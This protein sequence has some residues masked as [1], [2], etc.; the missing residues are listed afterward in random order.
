MKEWFPLIFNRNNL[1]NMRVMADGDRLVAHVG[2][3]QSGISIYGDRL[4]TGSIGAVCTHPDYRGKGLA[5]VLFADALKKQD[6]RQK[7]LIFK[8]NRWDFH[9]FAL[10]DHCPLS[11]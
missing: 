10:L 2:I 8:N 9:F 1:D 5:T 3:Y 6:I 4:Q 11:N 7:F